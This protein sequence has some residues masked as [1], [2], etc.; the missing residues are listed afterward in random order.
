MPDLSLLNFQV[1]A[2][3]S[4]WNII[5]RVSVTQSQQQSYSGL[6]PPERS[7][8]IILWQDPRVQ[9]I[10]YVKAIFCKVVHGTVF[11]P[12]FYAVLGNACS[13]YLIG[14]FS[15]DDG[16]GKRALGLISETTTRH[17]QHTF[18]VVVRPPHEVP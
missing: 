9:T 15:N 6:N 2:I 18:A 5:V 10:Y 8:S 14:I 3:L 12:R 17:V 11:E 1:K 16:D 7:Y 4:G 13:E